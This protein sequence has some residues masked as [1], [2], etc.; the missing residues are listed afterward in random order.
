MCQRNLIR[1]YLSRSKYTFCSNENFFHDAPNKNSLNNGIYA[2][3]FSVLPDHAIRKF[4]KWR[5]YHGIGLSF[6]KTSVSIEGFLLPFWTYDIYLRFQDHSKVRSSVAEAY[7]EA[8]TIFLPGLSSYAGYFYKDHF[9][10]LNIVHSSS[11][12]FESTTGS[13]YDESSRKV[14]K[15]FLPWMLEDLP[16]KNG[17]GVPVFPDVWGSKSMNSLNALLKYSLIPFL[18][19][20]SQMTPFDIILKSATRI[21]LPTYTI[22]YSL[23]GTQFYAFVSGWDADASVS[24]VPHIVPNDELHIEDSIE[25]IMNHHSLFRNSSSIHPYSNMELIKSWLYSLT[26]QEEKTDFKSVIRPKSKTINSKTMNILKEGSSHVLSKKMKNDT[27]T[28]FRRNI[29]HIR[30][31]LSGVD[32]DKLLARSSDQREVLT[33][34]QE[35]HERRDNSLA[36]IAREQQWFEK[37]NNTWHTKQKSILHKRLKVDK[38]VKKVKKLDDLSGDFAYYDRYADIGSSEC[39]RSFFEETR[40]EYETANAALQNT[41]LAKHFRKKILQHHPD[42]LPFASKDERE[43]AKGHVDKIIEAYREIRQLLRRY[44]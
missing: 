11:M 4:H 38:V 33:R 24:G 28:F 34:Y 36:N 41:L 21:Y 22:R 10:L 12:L 1:S 16:Y 35:Y 32:A 37:L 23:L 26:S 9:H 44:R 13:A 30:K 2:V 20:D 5:N 25:L 17:I 40:K 18:Y 14:V 6:D 39:Y 15:Q 31:S 27:E 43:E 42:M 7:N 8:K 3:P 29:D 19:D